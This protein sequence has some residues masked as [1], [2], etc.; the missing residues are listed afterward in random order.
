M[1]FRAGVNNMLVL[2]NHFPGGV[3]VRF[4]EK[5]KDEIEKPTSR[6]AIHERGGQAGEALVGYSSNYSNSTHSMIV[7]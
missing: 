2:T 7:N 3:D 6:R 1:S 5:A 4:Y